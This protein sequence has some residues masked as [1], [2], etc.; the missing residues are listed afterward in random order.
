MPGAH[1]FSSQPEAGPCTRARGSWGSVRAVRGNYRKCREKPWSFPIWSWRNGAP[2]ADGPGAGAERERG[3]ATPR[4]SAGR[5]LSPPSRLLGW[6]PPAP[7]RLREPRPASRA[8]RSSRPSSAS[9]ASAHEPFPRRLASDL[10]LWC[11]RRIPALAARLILTVQRKLRL[12]Y[13]E[14]RRLSEAVAL[15][16]D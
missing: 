6:P 2:G 3:R 11:S 8:S 5:A 7:P 14:S 16:L 13:V 1:L 9:S 4:A 15:M 10:G 12:P